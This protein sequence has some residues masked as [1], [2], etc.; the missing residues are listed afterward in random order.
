[1]SFSGLITN[2]S[3]L[4]A[5][6]VGFNIHNPWL[7]ILFFAVGGVLWG[8]SLQQAHEKGGIAILSRQHKNMHRVGLG[9]LHS[10]ML[11]EYIRRTQNENAR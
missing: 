8:M 6:A 5:L 11:K 4:S 9:K 3:A 10:F 7:S 2:L 1:M